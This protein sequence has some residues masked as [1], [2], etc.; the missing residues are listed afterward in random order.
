MSLALALVTSPPIIA[1]SSPLMIA[2][3]QQCRRYAA[4]RNVVTM[5][6]DTGTGKSYLARWIHSS[7]PRAERPFMDVTAEELPEDLA[8]SRLFGHER[9]AFTGAVARSAGFIGDAAGGTL[10]LDDVHLLGRRVQAAL[11][12]VLQTGLYRRVGATR[13]L[14]MTCRLIIGVRGGLDD[15]MHRQVLIEDFRYRLGYCTVRLPRLDERRED[16]PALARRILDDCAHTTGVE[17]ARELAREVVEALMVAAWPGNV[18]QLQGVLEAAYLNSVGAPTI[19]LEHLPPGREWLPRF[20]PHGDWEGNL[21]AVRW[22]LGKCGHQV[23]RAARLLN[24]H[25]NTL[26]PYVRK[27]ADEQR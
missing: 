14:P 18:R 7:G 1:C 2:A 19:R 13:D 4:A 25:R 10:L 11:L 17:G 12:R 6:G 26:G 22:A 20:Q 23:G 21:R 15:L 8:L 5:E 3:L 9:G 16:I 24:V 27:I